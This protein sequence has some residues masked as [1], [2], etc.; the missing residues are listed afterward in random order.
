MKRREVEERQTGTPTPGADAPTGPAQSGV[1]DARNKRKHGQ[2]C[3]ALIHR[4]SRGARDQ[5]YP[6]TIEMEGTTE[7]RP[8]GRVTRGKTPGFQHNIIFS[9]R[10]SEIFQ[11]CKVHVFT[12][13]L[14]HILTFKNIIFHI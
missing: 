11:L 14:G 13:L 1:S 2:W 5:S 9:Q 8:K 6:I 12:K 4:R 10:L 3:E 7:K